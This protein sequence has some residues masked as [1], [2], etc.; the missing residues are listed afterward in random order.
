MYQIMTD[1]DVNRIL[2]METVVNVIEQTLRARAEGA[3]VAPPRFSVELG[4]GALVFTA[5]AEPKY[6]RAMGF[7]VYDTFP[8]SASHHSQL[9]AIFDSGTGE[10]RG[11]VIGKG[12]IGA[13][14]TAAINAV[15]IKHMARPDAEY[16]GILGSGF[17][18]RFQARAA[19]TVRGFQQAMVYSPTPSHRENL[20]ADMSVQTGIPFHVA[21]SAEEVVRFADVLICAT[22]SKSPVFE[23][24]WVKPGTHVNTIGPK[25]K[26]MSEMPY[27]LAQSSQVIA[28]DS[29]EQVDSY[30]EPFFL[31]GTPERERMLDLSEIVVGKQNGR[32]FPHDI[33]L[34]CS[35]GLAGTEVVVANEALKLWQAGSQ[36]KADKETRRGVGEAP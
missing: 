33:T 7:R 19:M 14:R 36:K 15:A 12:L 22:R 20:V 10:L 17:Q 9:V 27:E 34:F 8:H 16:L 4:E 23:A 11:L 2:Q 30:P 26:G 28:T 6:A 32:S 29:P 21:A 25:F 24:G 35:V 31:L 13:L 5:G 3:L 1:E 18:S